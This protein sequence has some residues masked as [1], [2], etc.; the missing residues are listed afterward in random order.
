[1]NDEELASKIKHRDEKAFEQLLS[2]YGGL[3]KAIVSHHL[4]NIPMWKDDCCQEVYFAVWNNI[5]RFDPS[6]NSLKNW[7]GAVAKYR[8]IDYMRKYAAELYSEPLDENMPD[9]S[10]SL[11]AE[12]KEETESLLENLSPADRDIFV[13]RYLKDESVEI[14]ALAQHKKPSFIYNRL[15]RGR[16]KL[17][18]IYER[19]AVK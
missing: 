4:R 7:I 5:G 18:E 17:R 13:R 16:R 9:E 8:S 2:L 15:S 12:L 6:K 19:G 11:I 14:I 1:M 10:E 3:I